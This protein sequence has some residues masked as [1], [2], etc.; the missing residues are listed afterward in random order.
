MKKVY[1]YK[2]IQK[3]LKIKHSNGKIELQSKRKNEGEKQK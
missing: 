3:Y 1:E 2:K